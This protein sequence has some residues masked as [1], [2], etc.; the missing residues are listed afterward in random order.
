[1]ITLIL[2]AT[3]ALL[4]F[5]AFYRLFLMKERMFGF[6]RFFLI[7]ALCFSLMV[8]FLQVNFSF[9][10]GE[11]LF[12]EKVPAAFSSEI[13]SGNDT[14]PPQSWQQGR[15]EA[16]LPAQSDTVVPWNTLLMG[17]YLSGLFFF[18]V[19]FIIQLEQLMRMIRN[20]LTLKANDC[21]YVLLRENTLPFTFLHFLFVDKASF[22]YKT[23]EKEILFHELTHIRQRHSWDI[24]FVEVLKVVFWFNPVFLLYKKAMQLNHEFLADAA[25]ITKFRN[26]AAYQWLLFHKISG[27]EAAL[28][29]SS[30]F[31]FSATKRRL[32]MMGHSS[33]Y[34]KTMMFK[35][36]SVILAGFLMVF[37]SS[38]QSSFERTQQN[39]TAN[40]YE[41]ILA[42]AFKEGNP[43]ELELNK[44]DLP[45]LRSAYL[46][47]DEQEKQKSTSFP[48]FD[49][50]AFEK[51]E[52]LQH[53]Y[54]EVKT[55]IYFERPPDK[56]N[57]QDDVFDR[58]KN[59]KNISFTIDD[60]E[61]KETDLNDYQ[62]ADFALFSVRE[63]EEKGFLKKAAY[64][65]TLL[66]HEY[67]NE[68]YYKSR[69]IVH[70]IE[71]E[72]PNDFRVRVDY[73]LKQAAKMEE[74]FSSFIPSN[75]EASIFHH[76][77]LID[78][79]Q[80]DIENMNRKKND[81]DNTFPV[82]IFSN[83]GK[84]V[85]RTFLPGI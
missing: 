15:V 42:S 32:I 35:S 4:I 46:S 36:I 72:Y 54:P 50:L 26:K 21:T 48:F 52:A 78:Y 11:D 76:L 55:S 22:Q 67:Y 10:I 81:S 37:L 7:F 16:P 82:L 2:K 9:H 66:T 49:A 62:P 47:M 1:M 29:I 12:P 39:H 68:K 3:I 60:R 57:I 79:T 56:K 30:P 45:A 74:K 85:S 40:D 71:A 33:A 34:L 70:S 58:W 44:L 5:Y 84:K 28:S 83:A 13:S 8:P 18:L 69:K 20:N 17:I 19:R 73:W 23:I 25:V 64:Q 38:G 24:L 6:N 31:N 14:S 63:T 43:F 27:N 41:Q 51:L 75:F 59:T 77:R 53:A 65:V 80:E 61:I